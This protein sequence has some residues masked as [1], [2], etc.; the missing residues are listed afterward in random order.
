MAPQLSSG[1][2]HNY[3]TKTRL[4]GW[5]NEQSMYSLMSMD[6]LSSGLYRLPR[7]QE[8]VV[9]VATASQVPLHA[10]PKQKQNKNIM[11]AL[12]A[13]QSELMHPRVLF[14]NGVLIFKFLSQL[15]SFKKFGLKSFWLANLF[16]IYFQLLKLVNR[17]K[18]AWPTLFGMGLTSAKGQTSAEGQ[19]LKCF[20]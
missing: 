15:K 19:I 12:P 2:Q 5:A 3:S 4:V 18:L 9:P 1:W 16:S 14:I 6:R 13:I 20:K 8:I 7:R 11:V 10:A 17:L